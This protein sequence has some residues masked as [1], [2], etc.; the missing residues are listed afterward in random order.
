MNRKYDIDF[1]IA[2][3]HFVEEPKILEHDDKY[4]AFLIAVNKKRFWDGKNKKATE[5][6][7]KE[8]KIKLDKELE[9]IEQKALHSF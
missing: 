2:N 5:T 3:F 1:K 7:K 8:L 9:Q 6:E 4:E